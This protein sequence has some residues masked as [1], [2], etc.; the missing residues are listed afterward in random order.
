MKN[1]ILSL[2]FLASPLWAVSQKYSHADAKSDDEIREIYHNLTYVNA[3][4]VTASTGTFKYIKIA[5]GTIVGT[6]SLASD[7]AKFGQIK[8]FQIVC[9]NT[10][11]QTDSTSGTF[12]NT[13]LAVTITP[14]LAAHR[15]LVISGNQCAG[16]TGTNGARIRHT[17]TTTGALFASKEVN[18][19]FGDLSLMDID[20]PNTIAAQT[21]TVQLSRDGAAGTVSHNSVPN[22]STICALEVL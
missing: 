13:A 21:Y 20:S 4:N 8:I 15:I 1:L 7:I 12:A 9:S 10:S 17:G 3:V 19:A 6:P 16:V 18:V 14:T 5:S 2:L 22:G 11:T